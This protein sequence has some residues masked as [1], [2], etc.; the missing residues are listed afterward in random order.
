MPVGRTRAALRALTP[1]M[2]VSDV[3]GSRDG[4]AEPRVERGAGVPGALRVAATDQHEGIRVLSSAMG[5]NDQA[6]RHNAKMVEQSVTGAQGLSQQTQ[7][8]RGA[9]S[10]FKLAG[11]YV[12]FR[13]L[14]PANYA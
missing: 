11:E 9:V 2:A 13:P 6:T 3:C 5:G 7:H 1:G 12:D 8:L 14:A 10:V 4:A